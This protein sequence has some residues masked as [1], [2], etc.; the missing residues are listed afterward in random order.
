MA[1][2]AKLPDWNTTEVNSTEPDITH[3]EQGW[4]APGG[5]PEK[6]PF[7]TFNYWMNI[8][9]KWIKSF[10]QQGVVEWDGITTYDINDVTK[11]SDGRLYESLISSNTNNDPLLNLDK[12]IDIQ[13]RKQTTTHDMATDADYTLTTLQNKYGRVVIVDSGVLLTATRNIIVD[14]IEKDFIVQNDTL[15]DLTIKM[16]AGTG[17]IVQSGFSA[18]L[19]NDKTNV[20]DSSTPLDTR[21][22]VADEKYAGQVAGEEIL[23]LNG[24]N[25]KN[26]CT[27]W[28]TFDGTTGTIR[29][30]FNIGS[31]VRISIG[32]YEIFFSTPMNNTN[33][34]GIVTGA[35]GLDCVSLNGTN[36]GVG[37]RVGTSFVSTSSFFC[38]VD[39]TYTNGVNDLPTISIQINGGK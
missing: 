4:L 20:I 33:Y 12:W 27:A 11:G 15:Q 28:V 19:Y 31:V 26:Q 24:V 5:V 14:N 21:L 39:Y 22:N 16:S 34:S 23:K 2:P 13:W 35:T 25:I 36:L 7:Q 18:S 17:I 9:W 38:N 10:N 32:R 37:N 29:D 1:K 30:S 8:V 3:K 6:P